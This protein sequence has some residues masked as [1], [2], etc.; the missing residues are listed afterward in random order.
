[1]PADIH[2]LLRGLSRPFTAEDQSAIL[3]A[4]SEQLHAQAV[5][6]ASKQVRL[7]T[8]LR[9][10]RHVNALRMP[11]VRWR[12]FGETDGRDP[13]AKYTRRRLSSSTRPTRAPRPTRSC[14]VH[15]CS[16]ASKNNAS[17]I[18]PNQICKP[19]KISRTT[20]SSSLPNLLTTRLRP[21]RT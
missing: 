21:T 1:M 4:K 5:D 16:V 14:S 9:G 6:R 7:S 3:T 15:C 10:R 20:C 2:F 13:L 12:C 11:H 8:K 19:T 18:S 17:T